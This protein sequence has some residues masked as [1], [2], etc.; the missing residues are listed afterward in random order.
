MHRISVEDFNEWLDNPITLGVLR[1]IKDEAQAHRDMAAAG[2]PLQTS[3]FV[4]IGEKY[5]AL[6]NTAMVYE[7]LLENLTYENVFQEETNDAVSSGR[8][9]T[10][11]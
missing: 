4:G 7:N 1:L 10:L 3:G 5:F 6:I 9:P 2:I 8:E 11:N